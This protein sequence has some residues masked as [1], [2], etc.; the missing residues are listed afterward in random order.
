MKCLIVKTS[1]LGDIIHAFPVVQFLRHHFPHA[2]I[3]WM[4][5]NAFTDLVRAH[6]DIHQAIAVHTHLWRK[7]PFSLLTW[8]QI[9]ALRASLQ[10]KKYTIAIDLQGNIKSGLLLSLVKADHKIGFGLKSL[11]EWPNSLF[12]DCRYNPPRGGNI[13]DDYLFLVENFFEKKDLLEEKKIVLKLSNQESSSLKH[14]SQIGKT[15]Y[16]VL[17]APGTVWPNKRIAPETLT[18]F[19]KNLEK[20]RECHFFFIW[21]TEQEKSLAYEI[22]D[23][24]PNK[25]VVDRLSLPLL[26]NLMAQIDLVVAMDS[27]PLHLC[28]TTY[29]PSFSFF[30][31]S[32]AVKYRPKGI[33][34]QSVQGT[35]PYGITFEKRCPKLRSC[36]TG[37][38]IKEIDPTTL[39]TK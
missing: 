38:C 28:G 30:G 26:Q 9:R 36:P 19:L 8:K 1:S 29:T 23:H 13:R 27:L 39:L 37:R 6:P 21:G 33:A 18:Y 12:T 2:E 25:T 14:L 3:D 11:S 16:R 32:S 10:Q 34:H 24:F 20:K 15:L 31:P 22:S 5:E 7:N 35:C 4:V 17:V